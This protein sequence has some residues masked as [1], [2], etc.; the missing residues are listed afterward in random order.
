MIIYA[1]LSAANRQKQR[2][3]ERKHEEQRWAEEKRIAKYNEELENQEQQRIDDLMSQVKNWEKSV[4]IRKYLEE[5]ECVVE[6][7]ASIYECPFGEV[8]VVSFA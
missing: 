1:I 5:F 3:I 4:R 7:D 8:P 2:S 6:G